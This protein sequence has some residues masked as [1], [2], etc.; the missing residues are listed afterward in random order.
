LQPD[1]RVVTT[2]FSRLSEGSEIAVAGSQPDATPPVPGE[3]PKGRKKRRD[4]AGEASGA[5]GAMGRKRSEA[6]PATR[7]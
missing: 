4:G 5:D 3:R 2:G 1:E 7:P 6:T